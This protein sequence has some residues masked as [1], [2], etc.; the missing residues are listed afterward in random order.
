MR[1]SRNAK[2]AIRSIEAVI[3]TSR[4]NLRARVRVEESDLRDRIIHW[5]AAR[6]KQWIAREYA[7]MRFIQP[8]R[9]EKYMQRHNL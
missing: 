7:E 8:D 9:T 6:G 3:H 5:L 2:I 1:D 4:I